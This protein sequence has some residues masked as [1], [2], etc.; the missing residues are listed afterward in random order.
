MKKANLF[1]LLIIASL[2]I[3]SLA[4][5]NPILDAYR[6]QAKAESAAFKD[7]SVAAGQKLYTTKGAE[8]SCSSCHTDSPMNAG[9]HAKTGKA[10][11]PL[12]PAANAKRFTDSAQVEKWFKRN[13]NDVFARACTTQE[14]GDFMAYVLSVK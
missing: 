5:A 11:D 1:T 3:P 8:F 13:C 12:A 9:K 7:F 10:I 14:K 6:T 2:G 4:G